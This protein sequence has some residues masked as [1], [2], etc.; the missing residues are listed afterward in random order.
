MLARRLLRSSRPDRWVT[1]F[2]DELLA[3]SHELL[4]SLD[5]PS[6]MLGAMVQE[7]EPELSLGLRETEEKYQ[8]TLAVPGMRPDDISVTLDR[9]ILR[10]QGH[11][12]GELDGWNYNNTVERAVQ[13][14]QGTIDTEGVT[15][16][17]DHGLLS[18]S[19]PKLTLSESPTMKMI[20]IKAKAKVI[21]ETTKQ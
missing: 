18:I 13:L 15:A 21:E 1:P 11:R 2:R 20:P 9:G 4:R 3:P 10:I 5:W 6:S 19:V 7:S 14:P 12:E 17:H 16:T 8:V